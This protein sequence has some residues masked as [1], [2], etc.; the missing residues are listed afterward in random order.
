MRCNPVAFLPSSAGAPTFVAIPAIVASCAASAALYA[1]SRAA[2]AASVVLCPPSKSASILYMPVS[3]PVSFDPIKFVIASL[4][5]ESAAPWS[6]SAL[7]SLLTLLVSAVTNPV[8][9]VSPDAMSADSSL[10]ARYMPDSLPTSL[11]P[12]AA[13]TSSSDSVFSEPS[14]IRAC[15]TVAAKAA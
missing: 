3:L 10:S 9:S 8:T 4:A 11:L 14:S 15:T 6:T 7:F 5:V 1:V 12:R 2:T 13:A